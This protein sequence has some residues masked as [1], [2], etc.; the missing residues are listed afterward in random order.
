MLNE[1]LCSRSQ[2]GIAADRPSGGSTEL[3]RDS[4]S[5][6]LRVEK[7]NDS[8]VSPGKWAK[9]RNLEYMKKKKLKNTKRK[10]AKEVKGKTNDPNEW[11]SVGPR[12]MLVLKNIGVCNLVQIGMFWNNRDDAE[13][14]ISEHAEVTGRIVWFNRESYRLRAFCKLKNVGNVHCPFTVNVRFGEQN[15]EGEPETLVGWHV[16]KQAC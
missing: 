11:Q 4:T 14:A 16:I 2:V 13:L 6:V 8:D 5:G 9:N 3:M 7:K 10:I 1:R 12:P 15:V